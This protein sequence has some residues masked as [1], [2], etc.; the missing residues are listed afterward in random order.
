MPVLGGRQRH[1]TLE[2]DPAVERA[3]GRDQRD[4]RD[5]LVPAATEDLAGGVANGLVDAASSSVGMMPMI[6]TVATM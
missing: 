1:A 6:E 3:E 5:D 4:Q 2:Q